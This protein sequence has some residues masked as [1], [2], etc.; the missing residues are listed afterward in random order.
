MEFNFADNYYLFRLINNEAFPTNSLQIIGGE[1]ITYHLDDKGR[2]DYLEVQPNSNGAASD[3]FSVYSRWQVR[4][5][6]AEVKARL[7]DIR[8]NVGDIVDLQATKY[9][10]SRRLAELKIVGTQGERMLAGL[11]IRSA[12][13]LRESLF[14]ILREYDEYNHISAFRFLGRGWGHGVGMCQV[15]AYGLALEGL[16]YQEILKT[17]YKNIELSKLY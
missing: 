13:G 6:P 11:R 17:Y 12:L 14:I 10:Y 9:G 2:I 15:G 5:S 8:I 7:A 3:R 4:L 1:K 16:N